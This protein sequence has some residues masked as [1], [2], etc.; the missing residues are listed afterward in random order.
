MSESSSYTLE[1]LK[2]FV[3]QLEALED[4]KREIADAIREKYSEAKGEGFDLPTL[5]A[6]LKL[7]KLP[8]Y[9][10]EEQDH[11]LDVYKSALGMS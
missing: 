4:E 3:E 2:E 9:V 10:R 7:R 1:K 5:R 11:L 8:G 6:L